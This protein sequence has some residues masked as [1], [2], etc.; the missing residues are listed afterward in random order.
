MALRY[1]N[2]YGQT[3]DIRNRQKDNFI[4]NLGETVLDPKNIGTVLG[5]IGG[6]M[7]GQPTLGG[8]IGGTLGGMVPGPD[9]GPEDDQFRSS[10]DDGLGG[11][12]RDAAT[13]YAASELG[14]MGADKVK[15]MFADPLAAEAVSTGGSQIANM[16]DPFETTG[17]ADQFMNVGS[18][19]LD[20]QAMASSLG[21]GAANAPTLPGDPNKLSTLEKAFMLNN[22]VSTGFNKAGAIDERNQFRRQRA[23]GNPFDLAMTDAFRNDRNRPSGVTSYQDYINRI[24]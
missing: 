13:S 7:V 10:L 16:T 9:F 21:Q 17:Y 4:H 14:Q 22:I 12:V 11:V 2:F 6:G 23:S 5:T 1:Q 3:V 19:V 18:D 20:P 8:T 15:G 24:G